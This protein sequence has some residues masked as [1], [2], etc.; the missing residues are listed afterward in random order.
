MSVHLEFLENLEL[1]AFSFLEKNHCELPYAVN[2]IVFVIKLRLFG[3]SPCS[4]YFALN[5]AKNSSGSCCFFIFEIDYKGEFHCVQFM[6]QHCP[7]PHFRICITFIIS[8]TINVLL[9]SI[10]EIYQF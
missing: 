4:I 10:A 5:L 1:S 3:L 9:F 8:M 7:L 2:F 6:V